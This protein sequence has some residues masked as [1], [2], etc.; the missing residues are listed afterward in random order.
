[1]IDL[2]T[3]VCG[4]YSDQPGAKCQRC[5][6]PFEGRSLVFYLSNLVV[7]PHG[8]VVLQICV[9]CFR[10]KLEAWEKLAEYLRKCQP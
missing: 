1:M 7:E 5:D 3:A 9:P 8:V 4:I 6:K 10:V 2:A